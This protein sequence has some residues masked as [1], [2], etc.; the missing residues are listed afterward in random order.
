MRGSWAR[1]DHSQRHTVRKRRGSYLYQIPKLGTRISAHAAAGGTL[2]IGLNGSERAS[3]MHRNLRFDVKGWRRCLDALG[4]A[5]WFE[6]AKEG[7][8]FS[9]QQVRSP[10]DILRS[11]SKSTRGRRT[12]VP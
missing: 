11:G 12:H 8:F 7:P 1:A 2:L 9:D 4:D 3:D 6:L 5:I 10:A